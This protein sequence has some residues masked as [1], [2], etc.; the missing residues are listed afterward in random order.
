MKKFSFACVV[1]VVTVWMGFSA[2]AAEISWGTAF[3]IETEADIDVSNEIVRA[4]N[5]ADPAAVEEIEV[6]FADG[7]TVEFEAE[8]TFEFNVELDEF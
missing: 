2:N 3:D 5:V 8:H 4:V 6:E 7:V 1:V